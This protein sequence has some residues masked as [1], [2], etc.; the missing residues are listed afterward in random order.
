MTLCS[1][2][3]L[4]ATIPYLRHAKGSVLVLVLVATLL[5]VRELPRQIYRRLTKFHL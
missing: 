3:V 5:L 1:L 2:L 4:S